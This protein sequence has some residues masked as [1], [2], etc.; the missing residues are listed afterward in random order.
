[1]QTEAELATMIRMNKKHAALGA[2]RA[3]QEE[4]DGRLSLP[5]SCRLSLPDIRFADGAEAQANALDL[6]D[7]S[8]RAQNGSILQWRTVHFT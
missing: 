7:G 2:C 3:C 8:S 6:A 4:R 5:P 1:V